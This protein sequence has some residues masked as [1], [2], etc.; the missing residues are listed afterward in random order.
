MMQ[1]QQ[2]EDKLILQ[3]QPAIVLLQLQSA[4]KATQHYVLHEI[5]A[6]GA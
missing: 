1:S 3:Q 2:L 5:A 4:W 6:H